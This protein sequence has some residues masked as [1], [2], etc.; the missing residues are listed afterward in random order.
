[1]SG[2]R[3]DGTDPGRL[4][5]EPTGSRG[6]MRLSFTGVGTALITPFTKAGA[7]DEGA[8]RQARRASGRSGRA[9]SRAVRHDRR[10]A[11]AV[12]RRAASRRRIVVEEVE[13]RAMVLA[14]AGGYDTREVIRSVAEMRS[15]RRARDSFCHALL[16]QAE[17]G[18]TLRSITARLP[19]ARGC[20][21]IIYNV[22]GRTGCNV[23]PATLARLADIPQ[24][25]RR[26][27]SVGQH[28]A[29]GRDLSASCPRSSSCSRET[30]H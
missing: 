13:G 2:N 6:L 18:R 5:S 26:E 14:G 30:T 28:D 1:M 8:V 25:R 23:E 20:P 22:P 21:I 7:L 10:D 3:S 9:L 29:D 16:Q 11:D 12:A 24:H 27:R 4:D 17:P 15:G 19:T